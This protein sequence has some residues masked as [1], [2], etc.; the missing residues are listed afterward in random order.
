V[1]EYDRTVKAAK[2]HWCDD[3]RSNI[4]RHHI[5][6]GALY[7]RCVAFPDGDINQSARPWVVRVCQDCYTQYGATMPERRTTCRTPSSAAS[8]G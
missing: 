2:D 3:T 5:Y 6:A 4:G 7:V 1:G 8:T